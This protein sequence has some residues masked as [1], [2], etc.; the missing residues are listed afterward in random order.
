MF[1]FGLFLLAVGL[2]L[3]FLLWCLAPVRRMPRPR[4]RDWLRLFL[5]LWLL[6]ANIAPIFVL[7]LLLPLGLF[8]PALIERAIAV[9]MFVRTVPIYVG[10]ALARGAAPATMVEIEFPFIIA[11]TRY[12]PRLQIACTRRKMLSVDKFAEVIIF[13]KFP[14]LVGRDLVGQAGDATVVIGPPNGFC[15]PTAETQLAVGPYPQFRKGFG[16]GPS[17]FLIRGEADKTRLYELRFDGEPAAI[18]DL[19]LEQPRIVSVTQRNAAEA[20]PLSALWP[21][22]RDPEMRHHVPDLVWTYQRLGVP[23]NGCVELAYAQMDFKS[24][25]MTTRRW[26][27]TELRDVPA[28]ERPAYCRRELGLKIRK[29]AVNPIPPAAE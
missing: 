22:S 27:M 6:S 26:R 10:N 23:T 17:V 13:E 12:R 25:T 5:G 9:T 19:V 7:P 1:T 24:L 29:P 8:S 14:T 15:S 2:Y 3:L 16:L 18:D 28:A 21:M 11:G 4:A 20:I